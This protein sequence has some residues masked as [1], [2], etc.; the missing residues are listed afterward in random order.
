MQFNTLSC[1]KVLH[2]KHFLHV[3]G[4]AQGCLHE[5]YSNSYWF[6]QYYKLTINHKGDI[7]CS[8]FEMEKLKQGIYEKFVLGNQH[9]YM[10]QV[11]LLNFVNKQVL[12]IYLN[13][14]CKQFQMTVIPKGAGISTKYE[15]CPL[16]IQCAIAAVKCAM[17]CKWIMHST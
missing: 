14:S 2:G 4:Y 13:T 12:Q 16:F 11:N 3:Q 8:K 10:N 17:S 1:M 9:L 15:Q 6:T 5:Q 7:F